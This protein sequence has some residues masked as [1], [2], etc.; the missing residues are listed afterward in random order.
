MSVD[1][2][3]DRPLRTQARVTRR[4]I[5]HLMLL[6]MMVYVDRANIGVAKLGMQ[7]DTGFSD[8]II[9]FGDGIFF[10]GFLVLNFPASILVE[11][12]SA[13]KL[14]AL[15]MLSW[16]VIASLM[17]FL[18]TPLFGSLRLTT[19]FYMLGHRFDQVGFADLYCARL[20][21]CDSG[22]R[23]RFSDSSRASAEGNCPEIRRET[24]RRW[25]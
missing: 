13:R 14:I 21:T 16:G 5:P 2:N 18:D 1:A 24:C 6:Y 9:G 7:A 4:L 3:L 25:R 8:A 22:N 20:V 10:L 15:I 23:G 19:Q 11:R 17:S 12:W